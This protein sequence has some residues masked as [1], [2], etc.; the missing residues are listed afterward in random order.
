ME[1]DFTRC[2]T[3]TYSVRKGC[4]EFVSIFKMVKCF[5]SDSWTFPNTFGI[6]FLMDSSEVSRDKHA[7]NFANTLTAV[8]KAM[9]DKKQHKTLKQELDLQKTYIDSIYNWDVRAE[10]WTNF[11][12]S[13]V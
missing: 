1:R 8:I 11:L 12:K 4:C 3:M 13:H 7:A 5:L 9:L 10:Q 2:V 6:W